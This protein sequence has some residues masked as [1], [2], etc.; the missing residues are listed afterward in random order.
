M[1]KKIIEIKTKVLELAG[2]AP[3][4]ISMELIESMEAHNWLTVMRGRDGRDYVWYLDGDGNEACLCV[5]TGE[6]VSEKEIVEL[7]SCAD[8]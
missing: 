2:Y 7:L 4:D 6:S 1:N 5:E 3:K 8:E